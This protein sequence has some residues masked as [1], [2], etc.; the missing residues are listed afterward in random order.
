MQGSGKGYKA[1][2]I[3]DGGYRHPVTN[4]SFIEEKTGEGIIRNRTHLILNGIDVFNFS[5]NEVPKNTEELL[6][7]AGKEKSAIDYFIFH[8]ANLLINEAIRK[9]LKLSAEQ[10][11]YSLRDFGNTSSATI[12][13]TLV[14][15]LREKISAQPLKM[16]FSGF[17]VGLSWSSA[18][19][20]TSPLVC[21]PLVEVG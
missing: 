20:E 15:R 14:T 9:K 13:V 19:I 18:C 11:P 12:P 16:V 4:E 2:I 8:Q 3:P 10:V 21:P 5:V 6:R 17:G 7:F 1:I